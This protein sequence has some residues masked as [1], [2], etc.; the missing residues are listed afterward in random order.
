MVETPTNLF[1]G[2]TLI[3][4]EF[5]SFSQRDYGRPKRDMESGIMPP[6]IAR[7]MI[8]IAE[9]DK[10]ALILDPFCGSGTILQEALLLGFTQVIGTDLSQ[11]AISDSKQNV[12]WLQ[13]NVDT[14]ITPQIYQHD[15]AKLSDRIPHGTISAVVT[16]PYMGP[17]V[18]QKPRLKD[19]Q[20]NKAELEELY[21]K[22]FKTY[23]LILKPGGC[24]VMVLPIF[25][26]NTHYLTMDILD[27]IQ[28]LGFSQ[29][30]LTKEKRNSIVL[31]NKRDYVLR[32]IL[33][34]KKEEL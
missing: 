6:K 10:D 23:S 9:I 31:G 13:K 11:K 5:E 20:Q 19:V 15:V 22:A 3:V 7:M 33:K 1:I 21:L 26:V 34:W 8:N 16:E 32:E 24:V 12:S 18:Q 2:K 14:E 17:N 29:V 25:H 4:Q 28:L 30:V 27:K